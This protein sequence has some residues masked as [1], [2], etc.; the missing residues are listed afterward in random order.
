MEQQ[1]NRMR[2][3]DNFQ[4]YIDTM[5]RLLLKTPTKFCYGE[6]EEDLDLIH[7]VHYEIASSGVMMKAN[8]PSYGLVTC[9]CFA[10]KR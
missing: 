5:P 7:V 8:A 1:D 4:H 2:S 9:F 3:H 6:F 10:W